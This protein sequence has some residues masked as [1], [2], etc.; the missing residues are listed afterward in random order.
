MIGTRGIDRQEG[1]SMKR[2]WRPLIPGGITGLHQK[3][4]W[5][6]EG[7][8]AHR[9]NAGDWKVY[10]NRGHGWTIRGGPRKGKRS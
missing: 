1:V 10:G 6:V 7:I 2:T 4:N 5:G 3:T 9:E 8:G